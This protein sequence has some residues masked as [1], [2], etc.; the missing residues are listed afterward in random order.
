MNKIKLNVKDKRILRELFENARYEYSEIAKRVGLS[1]EVVLYRIKRME[2]LG[3]IIRYNTVIDVK[4]L[5]WDIYFAYIKLNHLNNEIESEIINKLKSHKNI[6]QVLKVIGNYDII[7]KI[8]CKDYLEANKILKNIFS[9]FNKQ[10]DFYKIDYVEEDIPIPLEFLYDIE[11]KTQNKIII[12]KKVETKINKIDID[13]L[14][15]ISHDARA[16][17]SDISKKLNVQRD[18]IKYHLKKLENSK[19]IKMYRPSCWSGGKEMGYSWYFVLLKLD[20][21]EKEKIQELKSFILNN[22]NTTYYYKTIGNSDI[23]FEIRLK[24]SD[25][26]N[27]ILMEIRNILQDKLRRHEISIILSEHKYTYFPDCLYETQV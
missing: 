23:Q 27:E 12:H 20:E 17:I 25:E 26:L 9:D 3:L 4:K 1:K 11:D 18:T 8:F 5:G 14:K 24:T 6:A 7:L 19:V 22:K 2:K 21:L 16:Q 10:L 13:I 15:Y